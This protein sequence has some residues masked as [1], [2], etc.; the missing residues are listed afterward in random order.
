M[1][2]LRSQIKAALNVLDQCCYIAVD[3][4]TTGL[5]PWQQHRPFSIIMHG[6]TAESYYF[7]L[8]YYPAKDHSAS[9]EQM[10]GEEEK[11]LLAAFL[12]DPKRRWYMHNAKFDMAML[13]QIGMPV[14]GEVRCS[15]ALGRVLRGD[16]MSYSLDALAKRWLGAEKSDAVK[17]YCKKHKLF[18]EV[19]DTKHPGKRRKDYCFHAVP[20]DV[21]VPYAEL[22]AKLTWELGEFLRAQFEKLDANAALPDRPERIPAIAPVVANEVALTRTLFDMERL[23]TRLDMPYTRAALADALQDAS[24][25]SDDFKAISGLPMSDADR[26]LER[27]FEA[28]GLVRPAGAIGWDKAVL[29]SV[30]H[31]LT[32]AAL[33]WRKATKKA[34][35][36]YANFL[37][38]ADDA[39]YIH[40]NYHQGGAKTGRMSSSDPN[41]QNLSKEE[42]KDE[43]TAD[44]R[45]LVRRCFIPPTPEHCLFAPDYDQMEYR[46]MLEYAKEESVIEQ[47][48]SGVD[49]HQATASVMGVTR[50][51][52]KTINFML[53]YG[54]GVEKLS[55]ALGCSL[56]E[57]KAKRAQYFAKLP[58]IKRF[59]ETVKARARTRG[60]IMNWMG[61]RYIL[62]DR[63]KDFVMPNYLIQGGCAEIAKRAQN[64]CAGFLSRETEKSWM[65]LQ[66]HDELVFA[67]HKDD[68]HLAKP[69]CDIMGNVYPSRR[70]PITCSPKYS[71]RSLQDMTDGL[72]S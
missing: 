24:N 71:W 13:H 19:E 41:L 62:A 21:I 67:L 42:L 44:D 36:F 58:G 40:T 55:K 28:C 10:L 46:L 33:R 16:L 15:V 65:S 17:D 25:A 26:T 34:S 4:E 22:D 12:A 59:I 66:I 3:T 14:G 30:D 8:Q 38:F 23:G 60:F 69:I 29:T 49:V 47:V 63:D 1:L 53:L 6:G 48:L 5:R 45:F 31:D 52:A 56:E 43:E 39:G 51:E 7:N 18:I 35:T 37:H 32:R 61:R 9:V 50:K 68:L 54:G 27:A 11:A 72:P 70:L 64:E 2:V 57:A 20:L